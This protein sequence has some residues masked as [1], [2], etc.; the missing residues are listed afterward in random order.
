MYFSIEVDED[1]YRI[2]KISKEQIDKFLQDRVESEFLGD[3]PEN[4]WTKTRD[5]MDA[6][7]FPEYGQVI[8]IKGEIVK[9]KKVEVVTK[10][11]L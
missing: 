2:K 11:E 5:E 8:L 4:R 10:L 1:G 7:T 6:E 3:F 9:P